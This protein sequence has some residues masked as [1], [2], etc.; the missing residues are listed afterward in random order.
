MVD[1]LMVSMRIE[2]EQKYTGGRGNWLIVAY[3]P[4]SYPALGFL[5]QDTNE[6]IAAYEPN[7]CSSSGFL[8]LSP[9]HVSRP[10]RPGAPNP[11]FPWCI[12]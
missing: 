1:A 10:Q 11:P 7:P 5:S 12:G 3:V 4:N 8:S 6:L 9:G 2:Q